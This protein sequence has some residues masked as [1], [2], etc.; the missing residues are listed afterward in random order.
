MIAEVRRLAARA[1]MRGLVAFA[2]P[3]ERQTKDKI[4]VKPG[5]F[6]TIYQASNALYLGRATRRTLTLL[7]SMT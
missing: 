3:V 4:I 6:G 2:D 5:H 7:P 1:G